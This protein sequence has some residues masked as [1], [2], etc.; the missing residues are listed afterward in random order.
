MKLDDRLTHLAELLIALTA[1]PVPSQQ[2]QV[3]AEEAGRVLTFDFLAVCLLDPDRQGYRLHAL[4]GAAG[5]EIPAR[6]Y[7]LNE[8]LAG[9][10]LRTG[11]T[12]LCDDVATHPAATPD[13]EGI[14]RRHG[15]RA[16]LVLPLRQGEQVIGA[17]Y[18][19]GRSALVYDLE[20]MQ[21]GTLL[22]AGLSA[23]L[24]MSRLYQ[25]LSD[26]RSV[27]AAVLASTKDAI[28]VV[29]PDQT[30]LLANPASGEMLGLDDEALPGK[31]LAEAVRDTA[32]REL[33]RLQDTDLTLDLDLP[34]GRQAQASLVNVTTPFGEEVGAALIIRDVTVL[35]GLAQ[36]KNEFVETVSHDLKNP[37]AS[38]SL[39]ADLID[40]GGP[41]VEAQRESLAII[42]E[43]AAH[44]NDLVTDLLDLGRIEAGLDLK[45]E[46]V[47]M[48]RLARSVVSDL[49]SQIEAR[50]LDVAVEAGGEAR[51]LGDAA[52]LRQVLANLVDNAIK[53]TPPGGRL[54]VRVAPAH[55]S[56]I[57]RVSDTGIGIPP[58]SL[59]LVFD[60]FYR[61][62]SA[63][64]EAIT[65]TGL[66]LAIARSIVEA[67]R[68][69]LW[70]ESREG[71]GTTF[72]FSLPAAGA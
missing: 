30:V 56:V 11:R 31:P 18:F 58:A 5:S 42:R 22:A 51:V 68:G 32:L 12:S 63:D 64:T 16:A 33:V 19:A 20:D 23:A 28:M 1:S 43:T 50:S 38:V 41:L 62:Q 4:F 3:L 72:S 27:L 34:D 45:A 26:E 65:G 59:P 25:S 29:S 57:A 46:E 60:K 54:T 37:I 9:L 52:R 49:Y 17:L 44:M 48:G 40:R 2:F 10:V 21:V 14:G 66:G 69:R 15:W 8:G 71:E 7:A 13:V 67:H 36:M 24:E 6:R 39:A 35:K 53:Y 70:V 55:G 61:V 47:D